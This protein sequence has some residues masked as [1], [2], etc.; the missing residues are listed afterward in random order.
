MQV[1]YVDVYFLIN[2]SVDMLACFL[3]ASLLHIKTDIPRLLILSFLGGASA[4]VDIFFEDPVVALINGVCYLLFAGMIIAKELS[5]WRRV[6]FVVAFLILEMTLGGVVSFAYGLLDR[7]LAPFLEDSGTGENRRALI[8]S[9]FILLAIG[10]LR[11][12]IMMLSDGTRVKVAR[13]KAGIGDRS[14]EFDALVDSGN[15]VKD[16]MSMAPVVFLKPSLA[17]KLFPK[18]LLSLEDVDK[19]DHVHKRRIRLIPVTRGEETHVAIGMV[20]D[21]ASLPDEGGSI[22]ITLAIDKEEGTYGGYLALMPSSVL[23]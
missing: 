13:M 10:V 23:E 21:E 19:L 20:P 11:L 22:R 17:E 6:R 16:P 1:L 15:L 18:E 7:Y 14:I 12:F 3:T 8:L 4:L 9:V 5:L 2:F